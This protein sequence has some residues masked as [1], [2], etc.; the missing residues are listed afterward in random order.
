MTVE[1]Y[2]A[3]PNQLIETI[4]VTESALG[5]FRHLLAK[6]AKKGVRISLKEAG[7][8]GF[9][10]VIEEV[11]GPKDS[12]TVRCLTPGVD[13]YVETGCLAAL[14]GLEIDLTQVGLNKNLVMNN[15]NVKD[16]C[17]CGE[18]FNV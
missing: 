10:Y 17:G 15:P 3:S 18:S 7:C 9:K 1:T 8:T 12:D 5:H 2:N 13:L 4:Q 14:K 16:A 6:N 11:E